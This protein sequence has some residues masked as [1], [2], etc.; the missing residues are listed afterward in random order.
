MPARIPPQNIVILCIPP[1]D[2]FNVEGPM[3]AFRLAN[4]LA[5]KKSSYQIELV[6]TR[7]DLAIESETGIN[8]QAHYSLSDERWQNAKIDTLIITSNILLSSGNPPDAIKWINTQTK[9]ARRICSLCGGIFALAQTGML[10]G[11]RVTTHWRVVEQFA[12]QHPQIKVDDQP[13]WVK[14]G[15]IY[16]SAG[17][18]ASIDMALSLIAEDRGDALAADVSREMVLFLRRP[19]HQPQQSL[20]LLA[21]SSNNRNLKALQPWLQEHLTQELS[22]EILADQL[23]MSR[24]TLIRIFKTELNTTPAKYVENVRLETARRF[25]L[26]TS[27]NLDRIAARCGFTSADVMRRV[28][29]RNLGISQL[30]YRQQFSSSE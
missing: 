3:E 18:S 10:N 4:R 27:M 15:N 22:V 11:K 30:H 5:N 16:T 23:A 21:Q 2:L 19:G 26:M 8:L 7:A 6:S 14:D 25:L 29:M 13:V 12:Q 24:S 17:M 9:N 28:F 20:S 1:I